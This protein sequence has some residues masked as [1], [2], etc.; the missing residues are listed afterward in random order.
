MGPDGAGGCVIG[1]SFLFSCVCCSRDAPLRAWPHDRC[2]LRSA[3]AQA[4]G[5]SPEACRLPV[6]HA[7]TNAPW[8]CRAKGEKAPDRKTRKLVCIP[9]VLSISHMQRLL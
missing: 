4:S 7:R 3:G 2:P 9:L 8:I 5:G 1:S 6:G